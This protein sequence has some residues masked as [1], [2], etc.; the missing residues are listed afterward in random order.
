MKE[1]GRN[2]RLRLLAGRRTRAVRVVGRLT[3][4]SSSRSSAVLVLADGLRIDARVEDQAVEALR[5][6]LGEDVV[7]SGVAFF[8]TAGRLITL[9][10]EAFDR[11]RLEDGIF[12]HSSAAARPRFLIDA[13][14][15]A[16]ETSVSTF[17]GTWPGDESDAELLEQLRAI[18]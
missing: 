7:V 1:D 5:S 12:R 16:K 4:V 8:G 3:T 11:A 10:V 13:A 2:G 18:E 9:E 15:R 6:L 17:F 14:E